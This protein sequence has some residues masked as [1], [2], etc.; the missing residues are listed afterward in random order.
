MYI[1]IKNALL[2][3]IFL[4]SSSI[5]IGYLFW[6]LI[7]DAYIT[8]IWVE[9]P[10]CFYNNDQNIAIEAPEKI[11]V[12]LKGKRSRLYNLDKKSLAIH[13][14]AQD[15]KPALNSCKL[16]A[17]HL[18]LPSGIILSDYC[19]GNLIIKLGRSC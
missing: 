5:I 15:L 6:L 18:F 2:S 14:N 12:Q 13:I 19:P 7:S 4:K 1:N 17:D 8:N 9:V 3:N 10:L 16:T 11:Y